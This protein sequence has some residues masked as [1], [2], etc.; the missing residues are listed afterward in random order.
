MNVADSHSKATVTP[1]TPVVAFFLSAEAGRLGIGVQLPHLY[2]SHITTQLRSKATVTPGLDPRRGLLPLG[3]SCVRG[4]FE[5]NYFT[6]VCS[7][8]EEGSYLR[9]IDLCI[10]QLYNWVKRL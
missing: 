8:S 2:S 6:E 9:L 7:G 5:N 10:T 1:L 4:Q 3:G